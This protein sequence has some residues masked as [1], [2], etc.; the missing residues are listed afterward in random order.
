[1]KIYRKYI[2]EAKSIN[3]K[4]R[5]ALVKILNS[6]VFFEKVERKTEVVINIAPIRRKIA[7]ITVFVTMIVEIDCIKR[8]KV[9]AKFSPNIAISFQEQSF[10]TSFVTSIT[11]KPKKSPDKIAQGVKFVRLTA[12]KAKRMIAVKLQEE[13]IISF[14]LPVRLQE[15]ASNVIM[16]ARAIVIKRVH[17]PYE[18]ERFALTSARTR[19]DKGARHLKR[20]LC[21]D[22]S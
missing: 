3:D 17:A 22:L 9:A 4:I 13:E 19:Q 8:M 16:I 18:D 10:L 15:N 5:K 1:M 14:A 21:H 7:A 6:L 2:E 20:M 11:P 12:A